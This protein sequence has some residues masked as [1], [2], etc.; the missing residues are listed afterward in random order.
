MVF[1]VHH[2]ISSMITVENMILQGVMKCPECRD[3]FPLRISADDVSFFDLFFFHLSNFVVQ[4]IFL[5]NIS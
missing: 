4:S 5:E 1:I 2:K 3:K